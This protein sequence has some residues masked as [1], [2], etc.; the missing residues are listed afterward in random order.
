MGFQSFIEAEIAHYRGDD[1]VILQHIYGLQVLC[2]DEHDLIAVDNL[3]IFIHCNNAVAV[4]IEGQT[5]IH[6]LFLDR[7]S[8]RLNSSHV[9]I[10][11]AVFCS[12]K[13]ITSE[14]V[15]NIFNSSNSLI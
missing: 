2:Q 11:Y 7:K 5:E 15:N 14:Q 9:A 12:K 3:S 13:K 6:F 1:H 8:T 4:T 10:S